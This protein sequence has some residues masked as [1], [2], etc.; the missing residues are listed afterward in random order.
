MPE[1]V[2]V[3]VHDQHV[4]RDG[5]PQDAGERGVVEPGHGR[6]Q[7]V[8]D[9]GAAAAGV[10]QDVLRLL[11]QPLDAREQQVAQRLGQL[12]RQRAVVVEQRLD[13]QG[14][15]LAAGLDPL[16][17]AGRRGVAEQLGDER[18]D[19]AAGQPGR[20]RSGG[21]GRAAPGRRAAGAAGGCGAARPTGT[22]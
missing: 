6:Q 13:E 12:A 14:V 11:G 9:A 2:A 17:E 10:P 22:S 5:G 1:R 15:A 18:G 16:D 19:V 7:G 4:R 21:R 8:L 20:S 3:A